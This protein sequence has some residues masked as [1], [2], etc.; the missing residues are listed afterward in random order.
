MGSVRMEL[1]T[2]L[3]V[4]GLLDLLLC[5]F[6]HRAA[7]RRSGWTGMLLISALL[8]KHVISEI[9]S[10]LVEGARDLVAQL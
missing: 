4:G 9:S 1:D 10:E 2:H 3:E 6:W 5:C 8:D 7:Y